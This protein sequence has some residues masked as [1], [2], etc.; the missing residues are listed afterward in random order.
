[1]LINVGDD[2]I[3]GQVSLGCMKRVVEKANKMLYYENEVR[4]HREE[5]P[6]LV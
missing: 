1:M 5:M 6:R 4:P 2:T 3:P